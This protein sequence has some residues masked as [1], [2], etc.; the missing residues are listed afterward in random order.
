MSPRSKISYD[1]IVIGS[2]LFLMLL[3]TSIVTEGTPESDRM[4]LTF[5]H[6]FRTPSLDTFFKAV[7]WLGS[8]KILLPLYLALLG[9]IYHRRCGKRVFLAASSFLL[10]FATTSILKFF[11]ARIRPDFFPDRIVPL[12]ADPSFPS[13]HTTQAFS[14]VLTLW[15]VFYV[16]RTPM[17]S[18]LLLLLL[19]L[20]AL[21]G[22]SRIYLQVH[23]PSD[24]AAGL[25]VALFWTVL[26]H[27]F[28]TKGDIR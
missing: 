21:V 25:L 6:S 27:Y 22:G 7:T 12:P 11:I 14:F 8:V 28:L 9:W 17:K 19:S 10:A 24:V 1:L 16:A 13:G 4:I 15:L 20:A 3:L 23:F 5:F 2:A 18:G 26:L